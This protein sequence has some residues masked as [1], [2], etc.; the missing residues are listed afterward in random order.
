MGGTKLPIFAKP[1]GFGRVCLAE[2]ADSA[3]N[4]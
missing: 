4:D 1:P 3:E 2:P